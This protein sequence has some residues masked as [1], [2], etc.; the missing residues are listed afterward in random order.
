MN[1]LLIVSLCVLRI[2]YLYLMNHD[3][4]FRRCEGCNDLKIKVINHVSIYILYIIDILY[5]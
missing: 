1:S 4:R 5:I 3:N 2:I